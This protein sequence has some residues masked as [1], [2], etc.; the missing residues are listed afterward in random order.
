V[1]T[2]SSASGSGCRGWAAGKKR[3]V[4]LPAPGCQPGLG[5]GPGP[6]GTGRSS[7]QARTRESARAPSTDL[8]S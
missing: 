4:G 8:P 1:Q 6:G 7:G 2:Q 3:V 5:P